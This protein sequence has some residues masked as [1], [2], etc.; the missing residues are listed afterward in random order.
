MPEGRIQQLC[1]PEQERDQW[2]H[3]PTQQC[4]E[5]SRMSC[6]LSSKYFGFFGFEI[7]I[8]QSDRIVECRPL[9]LVIFVYL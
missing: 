6:L 8:I 4:Q 2:R 3:G 9:V 1:Q 5:D 7:F